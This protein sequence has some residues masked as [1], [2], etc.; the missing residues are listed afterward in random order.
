MAAPLKSLFVDTVGWY[1]LSDQAEARHGAAG[2]CR[3]RWLERRGVLV[4][5]DFVLDET[6]TLL[7]ARLGIEQAKCWWEIYGSSPRVRWERID[8]ERLERAR[9]LFFQWSDKEFSL[10]D[11]TSFVL[12]REMKISS[13]L[14]SDIH[15]KQAGFDILP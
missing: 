12:M 6:L 14:T 2:R 13:A 11:C 15:F 9:R 3:D 1:L 7:R 10:T 5:S 8:P 4:S